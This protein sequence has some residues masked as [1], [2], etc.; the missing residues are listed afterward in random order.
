MDGD[1][2]IGRIRL[3]HDLGDPDA[4]RAR[5]A[6]RVRVAAGGRRGTCEWAGRARHDAARHVRHHLAPLRAGRGP[7]RRAAPHRIVHFRSVADVAL[8]DGG[9]HARRASALRGERRAGRGPELERPGRG[10]RRSAPD[11]P[12][13]DLGTR[14]ARAPSRERA[15]PLRGPVLRLGRALAS[16]REPSRHPRGV[17]RHL[18]A[19]PSLVSQL[20]LRGRPRSRSGVHG[21]PGLARHLPLRPLAPRGGAHP[22]HGRGA[23]RDE[24]RRRGACGG[25][26]RLP[27]RRERQRG[28]VGGAA[29]ERALEPDGRGPARLS[30][31]RV[32]RGPGVS[33][34]AT[35][36]SGP[37]L[38]KGVPLSKIVD[39]AMLL[40]HAH[41]EPVLLARRGNDLFAIGAFCTHY[42]APLADGLLVED[43]VRC[44]WHHACFSLRT[45]EA[46]RAPALNPVSSFRVEQRSGT[47]F[48][49]EKIEPTGPP[50]PPPGERMP[51]SVVILGGGGAGNAAAEMLRRRGYP[52]RITMLSADP[53]LPCDRPNLSKGYLAGTASEESNIL[54]SPEFYRDHGIDLKLNASVD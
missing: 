41:G 24:S 27:G 45:G 13:A 36:L 22:D 31:L 8:P 43:T 33:D 26:S 20:P 44:P 12:A 16:L 39:G 38:A 15:L 14:G 32:V 49:G 40:G 5:S 53:S 21:G 11:G 34:A 35:A 37:D 23:A 19:S 3:R 30:F 7:P 10:G 6:P 54:R 47:V 1:G 29:R 46:L 51:G 48:V 9:R 28:G 25:A 4:P 18:R 2:R 52:G 42:G 17:E 50:A